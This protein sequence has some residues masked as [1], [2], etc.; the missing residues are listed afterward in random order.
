VV[1]GSGNSTEQKKAI[2][3]PL[4]LANGHP[5]RREGKHGREK[6]RKRR[7]G[8]MSYTL[9]EEGG[10]SSIYSSVLLLMYVHLTASDVSSQNIA[11]YGGK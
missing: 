4:T 7:H 5:V 1:A 3:G 8:I 10:R 6:K 2:Y 11:L 9:G